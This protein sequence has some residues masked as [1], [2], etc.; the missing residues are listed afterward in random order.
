MNKDPP[1]HHQAAALHP[2]LPRHVRTLIRGLSTTLGYQERQGVTVRSYFPP[3]RTEDVKPWR[4]PGA[5]NMS[6]GVHNGS[7]T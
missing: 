3:T 4:G 5:L 7:A 2:R 1:T 6:T